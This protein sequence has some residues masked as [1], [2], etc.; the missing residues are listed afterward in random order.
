MIFCWPQFLHLLV[1]IRYKLE[2]QIQ[3]SKCRIKYYYFIKYLKGL[4]S[5]I[6]H[7]DNRIE[8]KFAAVSESTSNQPTWHFEWVSLS[9]LDRKWQFKQ[10]VSHHTMI[11]QLDKHHC[12]M[13]RHCV[14][15]LKQ[16]FMHM[17][18][19]FARTAIQTNGQSFQRCKRTM[20]K[21]F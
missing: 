11:E 7:P 3:F 5:N 10:E 14:S 16:V 21:E 18:T 2:N 8:N 12:N 19:V 15:N 17:H 1:E 13:I 20:Q 4:Q 9:S 6:S